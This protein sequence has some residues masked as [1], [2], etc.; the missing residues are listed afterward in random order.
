MELLKKNMLEKKMS[1]FQSIINIEDEYTINLIEST[2]QYSNIEKNR[3]NLKPFSLDEF[4]DL[5][6]KAQDDI[7]NNRLIS[8]EDLEKEINLWN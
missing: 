6:D 8:N 3:N 5:L 7:L 1:L 4:Y 2:L